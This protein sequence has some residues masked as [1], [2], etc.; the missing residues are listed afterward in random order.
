MS[1]KTSTDSQQQETK[2]PAFVD[3]LLKNGTI[4]LTSLT[5]EDFAPMLAKIPD[6]VKYSAGAVGKNSETGVFTL[7]LDVIND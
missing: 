5:R 4:V 6:E 1:K 7:R 3:E 2:R